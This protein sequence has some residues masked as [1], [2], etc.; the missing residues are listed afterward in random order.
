MRRISKLASFHPDLRAL[1]VASLIFRIGLMAFPFLTAYL[2]REG[3]RPGQVGLVVGAF[4]VGALLADLGASVL[5]C[6]VPVRKLMLVG[7]CLHAVVL[8]AIPRLHGVLPLM[9]ASLAWGL[10]YEIYTP[11]MASQIVALSGPGQ[12]RIAF[13][14]NRLA[15][16]L[17]MGIGPVLGGLAFGWKPSLLF[18]ANAAAALAAAGYLIAHGFGRSDGPPGPSRAMAGTVSRRPG[19]DRTQFLTIFGLA[20]P[21]NIAYALPTVFLSAYVLTVLRLPSY[22]V[23]LIFAVNAALIILFEVPLNVLMR[24]VSL[25]RS[26]LIGYLLAGAGF[27]AMSISGGGAVL[28]LATGGW[29]VGEMIIFPALLSYV[30]ELSPLAVVDRNLSLHS[31]GTSLGI[32]L[33]PPVSL[34]VIDLGGGQAPWLLAGGVLLLAAALLVAARR[35]SHTWYAGPVRSSVVSSIRPDESTRRAPAGHPITRQP[36]GVD[37]GRPAAHA[38]RAGSMIE[39]RPARRLAPRSRRHQPRTGARARPRAR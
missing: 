18:Y 1:F 21:L 10:T 13:A 25:G 15:I 8:C 19:R 2:L 7:L 38:R 26:L 23:S 11:A 31:G 35:S 5:L 20:L 6:R 39:R 37:H 32:I 14:V 27:L 3:Y 16:N 9:L 28:L 30:S 22:W 17:G 4:G 29:T 36:A 34:A 33:A 12:S 24:S